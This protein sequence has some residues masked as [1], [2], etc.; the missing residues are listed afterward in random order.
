[1]G[2]VSSP[3]GAK[4]SSPM[5]K[6]GD[7][8][9]SIPKA[10]E[11]RKTFSIPQSSVLSFYAEQKDVLWRLHS[12]TIRIPTWRDRPLIT[13]R[14]LLGLAAITVTLALAACDGSTPGT[15][16]PTTPPPSP[17]PPTMP[18][19]NQQA[20]P[21]ITL[22][23]TGG[24]DGRH[25]TLTISPTGEATFTEGSTTNKQSL[26]MTR[27]GLLLQQLE[28]T[29]F[30]NLQDN[31]DTGTV[32]DDIYYQITVQEGDRT[33]KVTVAQIGGKDVTPQALQELI[34]Q[35]SAIQDTLAGPGSS[36]D[37]PTTITAIKT[38]GI[39]GVHNTLTITP[40]GQATYSTRDAAAK[41]AQLPAD[42]YSALLTQINAA[43]FFN[44]QDKYD[45]PAADAFNYAI[46]VARDGRTK[47]VSITQTSDI[48]QP[49][50]ELLVQLTA[51]ETAMEK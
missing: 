49:V 16:T 20:R 23:T 26:T 47:T 22:D 37:T 24:I 11:G 43:D 36:T 44:L 50:E 19:P 34:T 12:E 17:T 5:R 42:Q 13:R 39:A 14:L 45:A 29:D 32:S 25:T 33:K 46:T 3:E 4:E 30:F 9:T 48:P 8:G 7:E 10:P 28:T 51:I 41:T 31:Y 35:L 18:T 38:G 21:A 6:R 1:M 15:P 2:S 27:Y 40:D